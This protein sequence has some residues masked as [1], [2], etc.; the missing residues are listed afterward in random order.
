MLLWMLNYTS[1]FLTIIWLCMLH[2]GFTY[3]Y[4][5]ML[6]LPCQLP[7]PVLS[8]ATY[9]AE[10][11]K[12]YSK[13]HSVCFL[14]KC[15]SSLL[16]FEWGMGTNQDPN[17][18]TGTCL[19]QWKLLLTFSLNSD[20]KNKGGYVLTLIL[21]SNLGLALMHKRIPYFKHLHSIG[22]RVHVL[23]ACL[24]NQ[25]SADGLGKKCGLAHVLGHLYPS[26]R[27]GGIPWLLDL[28]NSIPTITGHLG[29]EPRGRS[30]FSV[31]PSLS[32][33]ALQIKINVSFL[34]KK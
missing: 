11:G 32:K 25:H 23:S 13:S 28:D 6:I 15:V 21:R 1:C 16:H 19:Q 8:F 10:G 20:G 3:L 12:G 14:Y 18:I 31:A 26:G 30:S 17:P 27:P 34:K 24:S 2:I 9:E 33:P 7:I 22:V 29:S 4:L 5:G